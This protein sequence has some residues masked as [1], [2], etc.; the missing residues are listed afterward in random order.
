[1]NSLIVDATDPTEL[2]CPL[3]EHLWYSSDFTDYLS[4]HSRKQTVLVI[5]GT[6]PGGGG[7]GGRALPWL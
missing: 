1:M 6:D 2:I 5:P 4:L 7:P 3:Q